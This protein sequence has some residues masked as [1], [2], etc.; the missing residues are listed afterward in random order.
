VIIGVPKEIKTREYRVGI[1]PAGVRALAARGHK[2]LIEKSAGVGS[3]ISDQ[4]FTKAGAEIARNAEE[5][6]G[7]ADMVMKVKEPLPDEY[8][9]IREGQIVYTYF[10]LAG[11]DPELTKVLLKKKVSAVAYETIQL[12]DRSLPLLR[13]MSEVA[14][15]MAIQVG[16]YCLEKEKGGKG[17]LLGGVPG[18]KRGRVVIIG[19]GVVG[20]QSAKM[21]VGLG[22]EVTILDI[23][24]NRLAYLDDIFMGRVA[25][26]FSDTDNISRS[27]REA[28]LVV[29]GVLIPGARAPKLVSEQLV[30][31]MQE[32]AVVVD[33]AVDQG[34]CIETCQPTT[35]D[36]PTYIK[37]GVVHY[38]VAN[39][40]GAVPHTSTFALTNTTIGYARK[41]AEMGL[42]DAIKADKALA[43]GLNTFGGSCTNEAVAESMNLD[44]V[45]VSDALAK[46]PGRKTDSK[47]SAKNVVAPAKNGK[48]PSA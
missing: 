24:L 41:I 18:V 13:P 42:V 29:G 10:H 47:P 21:A 20:T 35:H 16:A 40:P 1:V 22:A 15:K 32:G 17:I 37:H 30:S 36:R 19:G 9:R 45:A 44:Y 31:E 3:G 25:T 48:R 2:V 11:V 23:D 14:G 43:L 38:C 34:G 8:G 26:L 46:A 12:P 4:E 5:I 6:W 33:V 39:M 27:V 7:R 28:D